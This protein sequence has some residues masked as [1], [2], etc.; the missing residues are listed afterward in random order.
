LKYRADIDG[1]RAVAV[2]S[3]IL[4]HAGYRF[5]EGGFVGVD[6]FFVISGYLITSLIL[7]E[8]QKGQFSFASFY[9]RRARRIL[10]A[11][12]FVVIISVP[13]AYM[14]LTP[15]HLE[16]FGWSLGAVATFSSNFLFWYENNGYFAADSDLK[17]LLHTW[18][19]AVEEQ[20]YVIFP[21]FL[22]LVFRFGKRGILLLLAVGLAISFSAAIWGTYNRPDPTFYLL[23]TRGWEILLGAIAA[24]YPTRTQTL[25]VRSL[26]LNTLSLLGIGM[27]VFSVLTFDQFIPFPGIYALLPTVGTLL[28]ILFSRPGT[29]VHS[30]LSL[31]ILVRIGLIS[32]SAYLWH[33]PLFAYMRYRNI[34]EPSDLTMGVASISV[35]V[36]AYFSWRFVE[37]PFRIGGSFTR[38]VF[39]IGVV[40]ICIGFASFTLVSQQTDGFAFR[41]SPYALNLVQTSKENGVSTGCFLGPEKDTFPDSCIRTSQI[42]DSHFLLIGD[43]HAA[44]WYSALRARLAE[45]SVELSLLSYSGCVPQVSEDRLMELPNLTERIEYSISS[46]CRQI[47]SEITQ[48]A[49]AESYD[50]IIIFVH[51]TQWMTDNNDSLL[52]NYQ[53]LFFNDIDELRKRSGS[54][55][56]VVGNAPFWPG[57][58][59]RILS[60]EV[61]AVT[62][63]EAWRNLATVSAH[64]V[65]DQSPLVDDELVKT[66]DNSQ[67]E[68]F[69][70]M[71]LFCERSSCLRIVTNADVPSPVVY[72]GSHLSSAGAQFVAA[73]FVEQFVITR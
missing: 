43:S 44:G 55:V 18:S 52:P 3:V 10:P 54:D 5:I 42:F 4:F 59:P 41:Y 27:I 14:W 63:D 37:Q 2:I 28:L 66:F 36:I 17:P 58:L 33:F 7:S 1:L 53:H 20:F 48:R 9:E 71:D 73:E 21:L 15:E 29:Y 30:V 12:F 67:M 70:L 22:M 35:L 56:Y 25:C 60:L 62:D 51:H 24:F 39:G 34:S 8:K 46:R 47:K 69:S 45:E 19:L 26:W 23:P 49:T 13:F 6:V 68:Y 65:L 57:G 64:G 32:Y 40:V 50:G 61:N 31:N 11:L 72:D 16:S 38:R